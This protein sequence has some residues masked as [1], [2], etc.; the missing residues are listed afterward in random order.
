MKIHQQ[1]ATLAAIASMTLFA[2]SAAADVSG[3]LTMCTSCHGQD[4]IGIGGVVP[5]IAGIPAVVQEDALYAYIDG[6]RKCGSQPLM[7]KL[8]SALTEEQV[9]DLAAHYAAFPFVPA[10]EDFDASLA[11]KGQAVHKEKCAICH[12]DDNPGD[13]E[14]SILHGQR[15]DYLRHAIKQYAAGERSQLPAMEKM[16]STLSGDDIDALINYYASYRD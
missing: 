8:V 6:D 2:Q 1:F 10:A 12:G 16:M 15:K 7:C 11:K 3:T 4:G 5:I 9:V 14:S 13:A